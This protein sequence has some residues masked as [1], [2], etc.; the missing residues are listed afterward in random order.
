MGQR[1]QAYF[2]ARILSLGA[3]QPRYRCVAATHHQWCN[4]T[5]PILAARRAITLAKQE[6]NSMIIRSEL[7]RLSRIDFREI[8]KPSHYLSHFLFRAFR[9]GLEERCVDSLDYVEHAILP[10]YMRIDQGGESSLRSSPF[11]S[12]FFFFA[13]PKNRFWCAP[14]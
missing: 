8:H 7:S 14:I 4:G 1:H 6:T 5:A 3:R 9:Y 12:F 13:N 10:A 2:I 11:F